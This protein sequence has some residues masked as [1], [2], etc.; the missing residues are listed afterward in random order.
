VF[1]PSG[2][3]AGETRGERIADGRALLGQWTGNGGVAGK[4]RNSYEAIDRRWHPP[5]WT[6]AAP[7]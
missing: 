5:G 1:V 2:K 6:T 3:K 7:C 4:S